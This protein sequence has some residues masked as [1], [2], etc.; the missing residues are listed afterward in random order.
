MT[1]GRLFLL[2][3]SLHLCALIAQAEESKFYQEKV[4]PI[5]VSKCFGCHGA[6]EPKA[7][8]RLDTLSTDLMQ[9]RPAVETWHD[10]LGVISRGEMPPKDEENLTTEERRLIAGWL[11]A[12]INKVIEAQQSTAGRVVIRRLNRVEYQN[13]MQ[14]LLGVKMDFTRDLP[15]ETI[16]PDGFKNNGNSL[17]MSSLQLEYYLAAARRGLE[18]V[19]VSQTEP[20]EVYKYTFDK[21]SGS[22]AA[23]RKKSI[24]LDREHTFCVRMVDK[25]S[26][27]GSF[28]IKL[29]VEADVEGKKGF[30]IL[31][32]SVG[33]QPD[34]KMM[35]T[36]CGVEEIQTNGLHQF[37]FTGRIENFPLPVRGQGKFPGLMVTVDN[38]YTDGTKAAKLE[39]DQKQEDYEPDFPKITVKSLE[40][41]GPFF[42]Q[43]PPKYH[44]NLLFESDLREKNERQYVQ[45]VL[46]QF[47]QRAWRRPVTPD[48]VQKHVDF[49]YVIRPEFPTFEETIQETLAMVMIAPEFL[50]LM[51][52]AGDS[53][54]NLT[55]W[56]L[57]SRL[58]YFLWSS[59]PDE[60]LVRLAT[61][62]KILNPKVATAQVDRMLKDSKASNFFQ[63]FAT[64]WLNL[65][66]MDRVAINPT[67]YPQFENALRD[68]IRDET[69]Q[70]F[71]HLV[72]EDLS[73]LNILDSDFTMLNET[74]ARHY[75]IEGVKGI[76]FRPVKLDSKEQRGGVLT[77]TS[78]LMANSTGEDSHPIKRAVFL[79]KA[80][81]NDP[82]APPPPNVP[83]LDAENADFNQLSTREQLAR[84]RQDEACADC[85][86]N[87]D[88]WGIALEQYN[89]IGLWREK[90]RRKKHDSN[91]FIEQE[92]VTSDTLPDGTKIDGA[93]ELKQYLLEHRKDDFSRAVVTKLF[94]YGLGRSLELTDE[95]TIDKVH[96]K[97]QKS[98]FQFRELIQEIVTSE[99]F[100][101]K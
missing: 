5:L 87:I 86:I 50:Y 7:D 45:A 101:I 89:A 33:Y 61:N 62:K 65:D 77:H 82:P 18:R 74:L 55:E 30:P 37:E 11:Q 32:V 63:Q 22:L 70:F 68:E 21:P 26:E 96:V 41:E 44:R 39:K 12:E 58:S 16:S 29:E 34:T 2:L 42:E 80:L 24:T 59:M 91:Q 93:T 10:V 20:P 83:E 52:P 81:L 78:L 1:F 88:P 14:E 66:G 56:E 95:T 51:E 92:M 47:M 48:E 25:Y 64:Q 53:K 46:E 36:S 76:S 28:R 94:S 90:I 31:D 85:H 8:I 71:A 79:R 19:I 40:F 69:I 99:A 98:G 84:H 49:F 3:L 38:R 27:Q 57:I 72:Q 9:D 23:G 73:A 13:T 54:R 100:R 17:G 43:W 15:P 97:F 4:R 6:K 35:L 67:Y 60:E 75:Q